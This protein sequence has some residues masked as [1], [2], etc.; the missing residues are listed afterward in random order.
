MQLCVLYIG[1][2]K[3]QDDEMS[4]VSF[5]TEDYSL[6]TKNKKVQSTA[7]EYWKGKNVADVAVRN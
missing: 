6:Q 2:L 4:L 1:L 3:R 7:S 5:W